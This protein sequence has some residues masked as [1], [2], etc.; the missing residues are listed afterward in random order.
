MNQ[1]TPHI[2]IKF[3]RSNNKLSWNLSGVQ[4]SI[5]FSDYAISSDYAYGGVFQSFHERGVV[6]SVR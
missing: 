3:T 2:W 5:E 4:I 1:Q 6:F